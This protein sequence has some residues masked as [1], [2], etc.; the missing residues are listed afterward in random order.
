MNTLVLALPKGSLQEATFSM[1]Q[2]AGFNIRA[3]ERSYTPTIDDPEIRARLLRAQE[4]SRYVELGALDAGITGYDWIVENGSDVV[5]VAE[6]I[7]AKHGLRPVKWVLAVPQD[8]HVRSVK[9]LKG[10]R[11]ATEAVRLTARYL[12][13]KGVKAGV[14]FSWGATEVKA[15]EMA[16]AIVELTETGSS[17]RAQNL[18]ILDVIL[19]STTRLIANKT[20]WKNEWKR[21]KIE[22]IALLLKGALAAENK[23]LLKMNARSKDVRAVTRML[24]ALR[25]P[26]VNNLQSAGWVAIE[27]VV[28]ETIVREIVPRLKKAGAEGII[29]LGLNKVIP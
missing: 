21:S 17:L 27:T 8:S 10:K 9:D 18:R 29:E 19:E 14:E 26:T 16:D 11:I 3:G 25:A 12:K 2:K 20:A 15:P 5:E 24:P 1:M 4:I 23:V 6:L 7:Y 13:K 28:D 22:Q